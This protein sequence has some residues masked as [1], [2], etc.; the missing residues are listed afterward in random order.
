M[1]HRSAEDRKED[2]GQVAFHPSSLAGG[3]DDGRG[4]F[5]GNWESL[6]RLGG[7][8]ERV[9]DHEASCAALCTILPEVCCSGQRTNPPPEDKPFR[10]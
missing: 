1:D 7:C 6:V 9:G 4:F 2:L 10:A 8:R 3:K 5:H